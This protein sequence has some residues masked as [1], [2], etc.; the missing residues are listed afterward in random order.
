M[1]DTYSD[2]AKTPPALFWRRS[3]TSLLALAGK[4]LT[5]RLACSNRKL[6]SGI[7]GAGH[8]ALLVR[9]VSMP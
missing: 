2:S 1:G 4:E 5:G 9:E 3:T 7:L 6:A 8:D